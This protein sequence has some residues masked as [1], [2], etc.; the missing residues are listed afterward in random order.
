[1]RASFTSG[2]VSGPY[3]NGLRGFEA[4]AGFISILGPLITGIAGEIAPPT[5]T[6]E[7]EAELLDDEDDVEVELEVSPATPARPARPARPPRAAPA[8]KL[9]ELD[10]ELL[11]DDDELELADEAPLANI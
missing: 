5:L 1:M 7:L 2:F 3:P 9:D 6:L 8:S 4:N 10:D 11:L